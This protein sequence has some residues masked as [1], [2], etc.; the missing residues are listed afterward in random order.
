MSDE[1]ENDNAALD[2]PVDTDPRQRA[3]TIA[4]WALAVS[5]LSAI[6]TASAWAIPLYRELSDAKRHEDG[7]ITGFA[8]SSRSEVLRAFSH[9]SPGSH[10]ES[11]LANVKD[12]W[13]AAF[14]ASDTA[15]ESTF[16]ASGASSELTSA[17]TYR[18]C[19]ADLPILPRGCWI[20]SDFVHQP[21]T[22]LIERFSVDGIPVDRLSTNYSSDQDSEYGLNISAKYRGNIISPSGDRV[23]TTFLLAVT[24]DR[25]KTHHF[26]R[27]DWLI[28]DR[29]E[30][31][32][33]GD[34]AWPAT[35]KYFRDQLAAVCIDSSQGFL[36]IREIASADNGN[37]TRSGWLWI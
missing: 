26:K 21:D 36:L 28:E 2:R 14:N 30:K 24:G 16:T 5:I 22:G 33:A 8:S 6:F 35:L 25:H 32:I 15:S 20:I 3:N 31:E 17:G 11:F 7:L 9:V 12:L 23:C 37:V 1:L 19:F 13:R 27:S 29:T 4:K 10:A 18:V 34:I